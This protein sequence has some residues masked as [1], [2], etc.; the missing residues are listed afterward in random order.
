MAY[1]LILIICSTDQIGLF[2]I[3]RF[4]K[5]DHMKH[6]KKKIPTGFSQYSLILLE[7]CSSNVQD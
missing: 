6:F 4:K 2:Q 5:K 3:H 7:I 1:V